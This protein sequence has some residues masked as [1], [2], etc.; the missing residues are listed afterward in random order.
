MGSSAFI[1]GPRGIAYP[2]D[3]NWREYPPNV[4]N[5]CIRDELAMWRW[6]NMCGGLKLVCPGSATRY[7]EPPWIRMPP[8]GKRYSK[9]SSIPLPGVENTDFLVTS[10]LVPL[11]YD[12]TI[13]SVVVGYTGMNFKEGSGDIH[14]RLQINRQRYQKDYGDVTTSIGSLVTPYNVNSGQILTQSGNLVEWHVMLGTGALG[15]LVG[16]RIICA[17]FGWDWPR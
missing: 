14:W 2:V 1:P 7:L 17:M 11:G 15:N 16:G 5:E 3:Y 13:V 8:Q 10:R 6:I 9:I 4:W 12:S